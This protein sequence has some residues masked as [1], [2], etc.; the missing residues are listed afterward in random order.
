MKIPNYDVNKND[1]NHSLNDFLNEDFH[2]S[3]WKNK[4][5]NAYD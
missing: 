2:N 5:I 3:L 4:H 1:N